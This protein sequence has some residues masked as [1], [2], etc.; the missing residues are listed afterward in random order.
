VLRLIEPKVERMRGIVGKEAIR[1]L[2]RN[3]K[4]SSP[5]LFPD[6]LDDREALFV[7]ATDFL[8]R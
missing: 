1:R 6:M 4:L 8:W 5:C 7:T 3:L 2:Q